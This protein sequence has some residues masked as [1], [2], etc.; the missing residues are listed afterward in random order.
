MRRLPL[1][2][3]AIVTMW[4]SAQAQDSEKAHLRCVQE[5][6]GYDPALAH[7]ALR[8]VPQD[9]SQ[10]ELTY[11][12][13][14][15]EGTCPIF[16]ITARQGEITFEGKN[17]VKV[18]GI[19][20]AKLSEADFSRLLSLWYANNFFAMRDEYCQLSCSDGSNSVFLDLRESSL[21]LKVNDETKSVHECWDKSLT[22]PHAP[23]PYYGVQQKL[24]QIAKSHGWL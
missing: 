21:T 8:G 3:A 19:R 11:A 20:N 6:S 17:Y 1:M 4:G 22:V 15:C 7:L 18:T 24:W 13:Q 2:V 14:G 16:D 5:F 10:I 12:E 9:R 23:Q